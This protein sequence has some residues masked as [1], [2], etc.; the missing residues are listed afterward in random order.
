MA[1]G[2]INMILKDCKLLRFEF[3][4][5][6]TPQHFV[7]LSGAT[8][9]AKEEARAYIYNRIV[10]ERKS[11]KDIYLVGVS[12]IGFLN[13]IAPSVE[14]LIVNYILEQTKPKRKKK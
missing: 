4:I 8:L 11:N 3:E 6:G 7:T 2:G 13:V 1:I 12:D 10:D 5:D 14:K 9:E